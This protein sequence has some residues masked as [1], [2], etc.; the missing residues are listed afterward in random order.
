MDK[1]TGGTSEAEARG[2]FDDAVRALEDAKRADMDRHQLRDFISFLPTGQYIHRPSGAFWPARTVNATLPPMEQKGEK[3][4]I[5]ATVWLDRH[6][7]VVQLAW[8]PGEDDI[9]VDV[10]VRDG[11]VVDFPGQRVF[12]TYQPPTLGA[13]DKTKAT[14]WLKHL[15][16]TFPDDCEHILGFLAH[17]VQRPHEKVNHALVLMSSEQGIGKDTLLAPAREAVGHWNCVEVSPEQFMGRFNGFARSVLLRVSEAKDL[18][19]TNRY[20]FY[21]RCKLFAAS[22][23]EVIRCDEKNKPEQAVLNCCHMIITSNYTSGGLYLPVQDRRHYVAESPMKPE[24]FPGGYW[25]ELWGWFRDRNQWVRACWRLSP[26]LRPARV[27]VH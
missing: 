25:K 12:N 19:D 21:D 4:P 26:C 16:K 1:K 20:R 10:I 18:G 2:A 14:P 27:Q 8:V 6:A 7:S 13:G 23:P 22:P 5:K 9:L 11:G 24:D 15:I 17:A 3:K